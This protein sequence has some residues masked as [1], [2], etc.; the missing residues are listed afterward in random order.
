MG[1][2]LAAVEDTRARIIAAT[3]DLLAMDPPPESFSVDAIARRADVARMTVYYQFE[4]RAGLL[5]AL[6]GDLV[7]RG[8]LATD[9]PAVFRQA[10][11]VGALRDFIRVFNR[12]WASEELV[13]RRLVGLAALDPELDQSLR[14]RN[15]RRR[16]GLQVI[17]PRLGTVSSAGLAEVVDVAC[18]LTS[19]ET[20]HA[21]RSAGHG[22]EQVADIV[23]RL[24]LD[25]VQPDAK[26]GESTLL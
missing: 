23:T 14:Q 20:F 6:Y 15:E 19:F 8:R 25:R 18:M 10:D 12:F 4:S 5:E 3:R 21:L 13:I 11:S 17:L 1:H 16:Q 26:A 2:R 7:A 22:P 9:L 24:V